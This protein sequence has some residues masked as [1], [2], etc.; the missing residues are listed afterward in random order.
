MKSAFAHPNHWPLRTR[1]IILFLLIAILPLVLL[2]R[3]FYANS[4]QMIA[5]HFTVNTRLSLELIDSKLDS[6]LAGVEENTVRL[7]AD[8]DI[9]TLLRISDPD[10]VDISTY[11]NAMN[12]IND[13]KSRK[14][15]YSIQ[16]YDRQFR[17]RAQ[18]QEW[19]PLDDGR[20]ADAAWLPD[21]LNREG[22]T[23]WVKAVPYRGGHL[24]LVA[25]AINDLDTFRNA[26]LLLLFFDETEISRL[27][28]DLPA[29]PLQVIF[30]ADENGAVLSS[31]RADMIGKPMSDFYDLRP[32][33][34]SGFGQS[35]DGDNRYYYMTNDE[36]GWR[37]VHVIPNQMVGRKLVQTKLLAIGLSLI[38]IGVI[39]LLSVVT[40]K[41]IT[42]PITALK[43]LMLRVQDGDYTVRSELFR[44]DEI[45]RLSHGFNAMINRINE[46]M[47]KIVEEQ[48][49]KTEWEL[50]AM[51]MQINPHF[52]YNSL[53]I[54]KGM[55][56]RRAVHPITEM[57]LNLAEF[58]RIALSRGKDVIT[59]R[60]EL[61]LLEHYLNI[62]SMFLEHAFDSYVEVDEELLD[63]Q[64][65]KLILQPLVENA[66]Q[67]GIKGLDRRGYIEVVVSREDDSSIC[68]EITD[69]GHGIESGKLAAINRS[70][71]DGGDAYAGSY[72]IYNVNQRIKLF[73]GN[74]RG[75]R[76]TSAEG[77]GTTVRAVIGKIEN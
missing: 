73:Y 67:H 75:L 76:Y 37:I 49:K 51:Q 77:E 50:H 44:R 31:S 16:I 56:E 58:Y 11:N 8:A 57:T 54:I 9:Q 1:L 27:F 72:G 43:N 64:M 10:N 18:T 53:E 45:G 70:L 59:I 3:V 13:I 74:S 52:L 2:M 7:Y 61:Q 65:L 12:V 46:Q 24:L 22:K 36:H 28:A 68:I 60:D 35:D 26:G 19:V 33:S 47:T 32:A 55:A 29:D 5:D 34:R 40:S 4:K 48:R 6:V 20:P 14:E 21:V 42:K 38:G 69:N 41:W 15:I 30:V 17:I 63:C 25:R 71:T 39:V 23:K 62:Q 66:I